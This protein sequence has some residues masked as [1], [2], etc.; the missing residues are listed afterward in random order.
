MTYPNRATL[1][2]LVVRVEDRPTRGCP[3][4]EKFLLVGIP[5]W[6]SGNPEKSGMLAKENRNVGTGI[7]NLQH[8]IL[9]LRLRLP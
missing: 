1:L 5:H 9:N 7:F 6:K 2:T 3:D 4:S 8:G